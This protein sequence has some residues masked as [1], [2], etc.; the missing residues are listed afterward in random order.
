MTQKIDWASRPY[1][2]NSFYGRPVAIMGATRM[3]GTARA[4]YHL[5]QM[6]ALLMPIR[7]P[8]RRELESDQ[9]RMNALR[10]NHVQDVA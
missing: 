6:P 2:A 5:R 3:L 10:L 1:D 8:S 9:F 7:S 4:Q